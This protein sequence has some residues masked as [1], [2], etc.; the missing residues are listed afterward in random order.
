L[1]YKFDKINLS[2]FI[3]HIFKDI[4]SFSINLSLPMNEVG[5]DIDHIQNAVNT[6]I[7][8]LEKECLVL[9]WSKIDSIIDSVNSTSDKMI[10]VQCAKLFFTEVFI[11]F[12]ELTDS[13][14]G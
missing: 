11:D 10:I 6:V 3:I 7:P 1:L 8:S 2:H 4:I 14:Q 12:N 13:F 9:Y 5:Y